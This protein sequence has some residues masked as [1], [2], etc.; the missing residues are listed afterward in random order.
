MGRWRHRDIAVG[1]EAEIDAFELG[2][3]PSRQTLAGEDLVAAFTRALR[4]RL[5]E[6][7]TGHEC[8]ALRAVDIDDQEVTG[9][10]Q[11]DIRVGVLGPDALDCVDVGGGVLEPVGEMA[12][13]RVFAGAG[14]IRGAAIAG[15]IGDAEQSE[16]GM[17]CFDICQRRSL[18]D[19]RAHGFRQAK[20]LSH[21]SGPEMRGREACLHAP[22]RER[23]EMGQH[24]VAPQCDLDGRQADSCR[25]G[26]VLLPLDQGRIRRVDAHRPQILAAQQNRLHIGQAR[27]VGRLRRV[28]GSDAFLQWAYLGDSATG[29]RSKGYHRETS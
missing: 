26:L 24:L 7:Q 1:V 3:F 20:G 17:A 28:E 29:I 16:N 13:H 6:V 25:E 22:Q 10:N 5:R 14:A 18:F 12:G 9:W 23:V 8:F 19:A 15:A 27:R 2:S 4:Q 11:A 21:G